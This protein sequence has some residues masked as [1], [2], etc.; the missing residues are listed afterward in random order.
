MTSPAAASSVPIAAQASLDQRYVATDGAM[1]M[2]GIQALARFAL[3]IRRTD[4]RAGHDSALYI[5]GYEGSPLGGY[6]LELARHPELLDEYDVVFRPAV[7]E[8]LAATAVQGTQLAA[9]MDDKR[10]EGITGLWYGKSPG[11]DRASDA[12]R[13]ANLCGTHRSGGAVALVGDDPTAKSSTVPGASEMLL[14]DLG[15]PTLYPMNPQE[16]LD[17]GL[18][19]VAM[20]RVSGLWTALKIV[21]NVAD[22]SGIVNID[23]DRL[24]IVTPDL[25]VDG[26]PFVH[27]VT[28]K[29]AGPTLT[30]LERSRNGPRLELAL[31]YARANGLN[32]IGGALNG[33]RIGI[34][35]SG[36]TYADVRQALGMLGLDD[37]AL[38]AAGIRLLKLGMVYPL[39]AA[40]VTEFAAG[41]DEIIVI[42]DKRPFLESGLK[43]LLFGTPNVPVVI[44]KRLPDG[45]ELLPAHGEL[46]PEPIASALAARIQF[47]G[48]LPSVTA[49]L[50]RRRPGGPRTMLPLAVRT[51]Y[52]CSGCPHNSS[53]KTPEGSLVGGGIGC[54]ALALLMNPDLVGD[55]MGLT[56]MGGE[57]AQWI[58]MAP[59]LG[60][61]HLL[62]NLGD[63]T[64]HHSG[65]L[66][67]RAAI[68]SG[69]DITYKLLYNSAV[70]MTGGQQAVGQM[71]V[72]EITRA[73]LAEGVKKIIVTSDD[74]KPYR[75]KR[76]PRGVEVWHRDRI[77]EAQEKLAA[78]PGVTL[79][80]HD[81]E[82]ATELRRKRKRGIAAEP[83]ERVII[84]ERV[85]EGCGDCGV[86]SNCLSVQPFDTEFG[87]KTR[88]DQSS[89]NK[90]FSCLKGDCPSF[91]TVIPGKAGPR[92]AATDL[93]DNAFPEPPVGTL[94]ATNHHTTRILGVG[95]S[96]VVTVAQ[97]LSVA[98][99]LAGLRV[100]SLDQTGLAQKGGSVVS[101]IK[102][103]HTEFDGANK[104]ATGEVDCYLGA[105]LLVAADPSYLSAADPSRTR[106]FVSLDKV[107]TGGMVYDVSRRFPDVS[108]LTDLIREYTD[109]ASAVFLDARAVSEALF[110][111]DQFA[112]LLLVG[113]AHQAG[114][115][116]IPAEAIERAIE[117]NGAQVEA[118]VQAFRRGRQLI[119]DPK[120]FH[121]RVGTAAQPPRGISPAAR[122]LIDGV[123][124]E[125]GSELSGILSLR[126][127]DLI[128]YQNLR[129][130]REYADFVAEVRRREQAQ[131]PGSTAVT[132]SVARYLYKL[133]AYKDEYEVAR[134]SLGDDVRD[135]VTA[136]FGAGARMSYR[137]H[138]PFLR[139]LGM[140]QKISLGA[141]F[142]PFFGILAA[143]RLVRGTAFDPFGYAKVRR[144][145]RGLVVEYRSVIEETLAA[146][147]PETIELVVAI[148]ALPDRVRGYEGIK[149]D[150][151]EKYHAELATMRDEL[152]QRDRGVLV[153]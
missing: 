134:L 117:L 63:G 82:C 69:V 146:L 35:A 104:A 21:T 42:E 127:P 75:R 79:L 135:A 6:D 152:E 7:N 17:F 99:S 65:S 2:T 96:G 44:G 64:F 123:G 53:V 108:A 93:L 55:V 52:F 144:V 78:I 32:V 148:A 4:I 100:Q 149:L 120:A 101:D 8:E 81:Q 151:V 116:P 39:D 46:G 3:D 110:G 142:R 94:T 125:S 89:C 102:V 16:V 128:A 88:I 114:S 92:R 36:K 113:A 80:I 11:L 107:P 9:T 72:E 28:A 61:K 115:L 48:E 57:G 14:A 37:G 33:A 15:M 58:G 60:R 29:L 30:A 136:Q 150:N 54:H 43:E 132:E 126:I 12:L 74:L 10:V 138:P 91:I 87:R 105:D 27:T 124:A 40:I 130:A 140:K 20:S 23:P 143:L 38:A 141:W 76:L 139:A 70:A 86:Q 1:H 121:A 153:P 47:H 133:M 84:N 118:N 51:P 19:A 97:I 95:G 90:D 66:A 5:S 119:S 98:G 56:Q 26:Q 131:A 49:W 34:V 71:T 129:Y 103:S 85:C 109:P 111:K 22:G 77:V 147:R 145:E 31:R 24:A 83:P 62:Q 137:L 50:S 68:A 25:E 13:H 67:V 122:A 18:H 106:A 41:L 112:N 59:F 45:T 73:L